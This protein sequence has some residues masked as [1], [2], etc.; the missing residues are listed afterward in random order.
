MNRRSFLKNSVGA[1]LFGMI[2]NNLI[3]KSIV[4]VTT[5]NSHDILLYL[6]KNKNGKLKIHGTKWIDVAIKNISPFKFQLDTFKPLGVFKSDIAYQRKKELWKEYECDGV[7]S[8]VNYEYAVKR[9]IEAK[10]TGQWA[11]AVEKGKG[12]GG[13]RNRDNRH[14][15]FALTEE[16]KSTYSR[17]GAAIS[18]PKM[19]KWCYENNHWEKLGEIHRGVPKSNEQK[20]KISKKLKGRKLPN[21]TRKKMRENRIGKK[22]S[23]TT[24]QNIKK[25]AQK[26][27]KIIS[28]F[29]LDGIWVEDFIGLSEAGKSISQKNGRA[30]QLVCNYYRDNLSK[31]SKQC[32]GFIWKYKD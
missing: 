23:I 25:S 6:I 19:L 22:H 5:H 16:E 4:N 9:G 31:G 18:Y 24:I 13:R 32:A 8:Y 11:S 30:I 15:L 17:Q 29:T 20:E 2:G 10:K 1:L 21:T 14:G 3:A 27:C 7:C 12:I 26:K 28:K